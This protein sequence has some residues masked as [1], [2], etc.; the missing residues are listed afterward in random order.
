MNLGGLT[1][2]TA[3]VRGVRTEQ[4]RA[5]HERFSRDLNAYAA[6]TL[7]PVSTYTAD[8]W[9]APKNFRPGAV[10]NQTDFNKARDDRERRLKE[11]APRAASQTYGEW[12]R[13]GTLPPDVTT[14]RRKPDQGP[15]IPM[16]LLG[17]WER[18]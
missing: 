18:R 14:R 17:E 11:L 8:D 1:E 13:G 7:V 12:E 9:R 15:P 16:D 3:D 2:L 6:S 4:L 5:I 10:P